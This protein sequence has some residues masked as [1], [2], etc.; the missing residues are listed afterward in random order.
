MITSVHVPS[1]LEKLGVKK[2]ETSALFYA[3]SWI[4]NY[5]LILEDY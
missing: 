2:G 5:L 1:D 3:V 4:L